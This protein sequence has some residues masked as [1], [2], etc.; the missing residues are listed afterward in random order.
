RV[1]DTPDRIRRVAVA[2]DCGLRPR[3]RRVPAAT[4]AYLRD[5]LSAREFGSA[6]G[7]IPLNVRQLA[8]ALRPDAVPP[9]MPPDCGVDL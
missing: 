6:F 4:A 5:H 9:A 7:V 1:A 2:G 8:S 3:L